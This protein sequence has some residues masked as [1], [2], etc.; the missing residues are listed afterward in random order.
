MMHHLSQGFILIMFTN[1]LIYHINK[2]R[3]FFSLFWIIYINF[4]FF[5]RANLL[6]SMVKNGE[7]F[8]RQENQ[9]IVH[10]GGLYGGRREEDNKYTV[11]I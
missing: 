8:F 7:K 3:E 10:E 2:K 6:F 5:Y 11:Y 4:F 1:L 9:K